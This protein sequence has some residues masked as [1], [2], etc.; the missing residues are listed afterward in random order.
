MVYIDNN[1]SNNIN[2]ISTQL[3]NRHYYK[4]RVV[5]SL[6]NKDYAWMIIAVKSRE[7]ISHIDARCVSQER[8]QCHAMN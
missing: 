1:G 4:L 7:A 8:I 6:G 5:N 3:T 2:D